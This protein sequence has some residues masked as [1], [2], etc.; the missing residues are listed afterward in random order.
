VDPSQGPD[1]RDPAARPDDHPAVDLFAQDGIGAADVA[2]AFGRDRGRLEPV[3]GLLESGS[4]IED[5]LIAGLAP[6]LQREVEVAPVDC[7]ADYVRLE[8][9]YGLHEELF[10]GLVAVEDDHAG[11]HRRK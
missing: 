10:A 4:G 7:E 1:A 5:H 8:Q 3:A 6:A 2:R 11:V 9:A